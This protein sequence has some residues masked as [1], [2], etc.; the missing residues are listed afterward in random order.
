MDSLIEQLLHAASGKEGH[1]EQELDKHRQR[2]T[3]QLGAA[4]RKL[5]EEAFDARDGNRALAAATVAS[6]IYRR[7]GDQAN[8]VRNLIDSM[9][10]QFMRAERVEEYSRVR[11]NSRQLMAL[12]DGLPSPPMAF[13]AAVLAADCAF[14]ASEST[15]IGPANE[16]WLVIT[17]RDLVL[18]CDRAKGVEHNVWFVKFVDLLSTAV[19]RAMTRF[20]AD[21]EKDQVAALLRHIAA[22]V[23]ALIPADFKFPG[24]A[25]QTSKIAAVLTQLADEYGP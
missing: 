16:D 24:D 17:L 19:D 9:Q 20:W 23:E 14:F 25:V 10:L 7:L 18:A 5:F 15:T 12:A 11:D 4:A 8:E 2:I 13:K 1:L 3:P 6:V 22:A 21:A